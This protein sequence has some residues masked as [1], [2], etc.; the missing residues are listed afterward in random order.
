LLAVASVLALAVAPQAA[1]ADALPIFQVDCPGL[2]P[3]FVQTNLASANA[4]LSRLSC[5]VMQVPENYAAP[6]GRQV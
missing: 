1:R 2:L 4:D 3:N 5:W 6:Y